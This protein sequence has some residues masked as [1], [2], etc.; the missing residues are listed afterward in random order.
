MKPAKDVLPSS[1]FQGLAEARRGRGRPKVEKPLVPVTL[2]VEPD[3][4]E[5]FKATG[6]DWRVRMNEALR[7]A[8]GPSRLSRDALKPWP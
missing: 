3:V 7:K 6:E 8:A 1:F 2:R 4:L 5:A